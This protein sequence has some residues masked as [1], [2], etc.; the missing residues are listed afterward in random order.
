MNRNKGERA[1]TE[2]GA[3]VRRLFFLFNGG[4]FGSHHVR[5]LGGVRL[6]TVGVRILSQ[7]LGAN[8]GNDK[9]GETIV[10]WEE[11]LG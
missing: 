7:D 3:T 10:L 5:V 6:T 4:G 11:R 1:H 9:V 8:F 2:S